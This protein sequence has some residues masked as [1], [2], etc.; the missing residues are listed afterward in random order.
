MAPP[1]GGSSRVTAHPDYVI[2]TVL[3]GLTGPVDGSTYS[4]VMIP[5]G[6]NT[7]EW[8]AAIASYVRNA[9]GN[10]ASYVSPADVARARSKT[11]GR[12]SFW[13]IEELEASV[14]TLIVPHAGWKATAT[15]NEANA[16]RAIAGLATP[17]GGRGAGSWSTGARQA[18]GMAFTVD[19]S[20]PARISEIH[21]DSLAAFGGGQGGPRPVAGQAAGAA[22][23]A[24]PGTA[25]PAPM[26]GNAA[27]Q[28]TTVPQT[29]RPAGGGPPLGA[30]THP[31]SYEVHVSLDGQKWGVPV[32][33][34]QGTPGSTTIVLDQPVRARYFRITLTGT[35]DAPAW[36]I[37]RLQVYGPPSPPA[38][39]SAN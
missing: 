19:M 17:A 23:A 31:R 5:M 33:K 27:G 38:R 37:S 8:V 3:H 15:Q 29:A 16:I 28:P 30:A 12:A 36:S 20:A 18:A 13:T 14:P 11:Q 35:E 1:L 24:R 7:D 39:P 6:D 26:P 21:F 22:A 4:N 34:G 9:F 32:A 10:Q 25:A 2:K